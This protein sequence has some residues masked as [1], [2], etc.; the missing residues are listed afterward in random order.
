MAEGCLVTRWRPSLP[1]HYG[2]NMVTLVSLHL[3]QSLFLSPPILTYDLLSVLGWVPGIIT[4]LIAGA[5]FWITS[6]TMWQFIMK[7][8]QIK[9][10]CK[11]RSQPN[12]ALYRADGI[13]FTGDFGYHICGRSRI[14][15]EWTGFMLLANNILLIG[16]RKFKALVNVLFFCS[17]DIS[18]YSIDTLSETD[19]S[20][21]FAPEPRRNQPDTDGPPLL[22]VL[23]G[24]KVLNTLSDHSLCTVGFSAIVTVMGII[25]SLPRTLK[26]VSF[27]SMGSGK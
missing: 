4:M 17:Q 11:F 7:N 14:A 22:D 2:S 27:M 26:H 5:L 20:V 24:A 19:Y 21:L 15:Y 18:S 23:T 1:C 12:M 3:S 6:I 16:F 10:I 8:P 9:D 25:M 13:F